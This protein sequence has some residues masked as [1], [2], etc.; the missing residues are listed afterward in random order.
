MIFTE[1]KNWAFL[2]VVT[3]IRLYYLMYWILFRHFLSLSL[4]TRSNILHCPHHHHPPSP[5]SSE[6]D[7]GS[8]QDIVWYHHQNPADQTVNY[9]T[10]FIFL[11]FSY[12]FDF[13]ILFCSLCFYWLDY[14]VSAEV[15]DPFF[16][17]MRNERVKTF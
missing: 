6:S 12:L 9:I 8:S 1:F 17:L 14:C 3:F 16:C 15:V 10:D 2:G 7:E 13:G 5:W 11:F 4:R